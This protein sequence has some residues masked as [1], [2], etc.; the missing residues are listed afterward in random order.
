[1]SSL[2]KWNITLSFRLLLLLCVKQITRC[3]IIKIIWS[4]KWSMKVGYVL[5]LCLLGFA[6]AQHSISG[7]HKHSIL[8]PVS[9]V[10]GWQPVRQF[11]NRCNEGFMMS[12][13]TKFIY[14]QSRLRNFYRILYSTC[15]ENIATSRTLVR[16]VKERLH[17][18]DILYNV[19]TINVDG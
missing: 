19:Y 15:R 4:V 14:I 1:M 6:T 12:I 3:I 5:L 17:E 7:K 9:M 8:F 11:H 16:W 13:W 10:A 2:L 18:I